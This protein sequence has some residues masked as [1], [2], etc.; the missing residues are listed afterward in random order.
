MDISL[1]N[2]GKKRS[3]ETRQKQRLKHL[4]VTSPHKGKI[5]ISKDDIK[6][7]IYEEQLDD[8]IKLG[9]KKGFK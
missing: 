5:G 3:E 7:Y 8:Y 9:F 6:T 1:S 2:I 4:G